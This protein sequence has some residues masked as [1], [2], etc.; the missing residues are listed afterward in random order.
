MK[1]NVLLVLTLLLLVALGGC[2]AGSSKVAVVDMNR[3]YENAP[4]A[5]AGQQY[6]EALAEE[7]KK[8][9]EALQAE[10]QANANDDSKVEEIGLKLKALL[11]S[12]RDKL[13]SERER[14]GMLLEEALQNSLQDYRVANSYDILVYKEA[15][16]TF[17][18]SIDVT[19]GIIEVVS[20]IEFDFSEQDEA[21]EL[22]EN[23]E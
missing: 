22:I 20:Q 16:P 10:M 3:V 23:P 1:K 9:I 5:Q 11:G 8:E 6:L 2:K 19:E 14:V 21:T 18:E 12:F 15:S 13:N 4:M 7:G 17:D